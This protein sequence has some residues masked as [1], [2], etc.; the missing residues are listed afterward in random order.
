MEWRTHYELGTRVTLG[1]IAWLV[2]FD[3]L[4]IW[5]AAQLP[6]SFLTFLIALIVL[7]SG[8]IFALL[9]YWLFGLRHS[10]YTLDRNAL[11]IDWG[12]T[13]HVVPMAAIERVVPG[14]GLDGRI[15]FRGAYWP[16]LWVGRGQVEGLGPAFF[17][18]TTAARAEAL[19][20]ATPGAVYVI[21]PAEP[22][23][24]LEAFEQRKAMGPTQEV[25]LASRR[26]EWLDWPLWS[27]KLARSLVGLA[28]LS[29]VLLF[30]FL[31]WRFQALPGSI[32]LHFNLAGVPDRMGDRVQVFI[33]P[34]IGLATL[35]ANGG[36]GGWVYQRRD[37]FSAYLLWGGAL[38]VQVML[39]VAAVGIVR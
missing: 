19:F 32:P 30:G 20:V 21:S 7:A 18:A 16:G 23:K 36:L 14:A 12:P 3:A 10:K 38:L 31:T 8:P 27:D 29:L 1:I 17:Y 34:L 37:A 33:L 15:R 11:T 2:V 35:L 6:I 13:Q 4:L 24:F 5:I 39:W 28:S 26:M 9:W 25:K 22:A